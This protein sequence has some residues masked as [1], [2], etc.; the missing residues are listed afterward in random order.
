MFFLFQVYDHIYDDLRI[1]PERAKHVLKEKEKMWK[2]ATEDLLKRVE[3]LIKDNARKE[4]DHEAEMADV[5]AKAKANIALVV[6]EA[7]IKLSKDVA[8][9]R[10]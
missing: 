1:R 6:W 10:S 7:K 4:E 2:A 5:I 3:L 9:A 8:N